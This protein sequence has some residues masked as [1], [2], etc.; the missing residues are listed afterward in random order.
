MIKTVISAE[1][2]SA[3][4]KKNIVVK[5]VCFEVKQGEILTLIGPNGAG[6]STVLK[7][8]MGHL[9]KLGGRVVISGTN[10][11]NISPAELSRRLSVLLTERIRPEL[12]TCRQVAETGRYPYTG[13]F[14]LLSDEDKKAVE[15]AVKAVEMG[16]FADADFNSV[17]D[18]Q[19]QRAMLARAIC[20]EPEILILD[21]PTSYLDIRHKIVFVEILRQLISERNIGVILSMHELELAKKISDKVLCIKDGQVILA[22]SPGE[23]FT[24]ENI[25]KIYGIP[26]ELYKKY[27]G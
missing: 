17:S 4:H 23:I 5:G 25:C 10:S 13:R 6:K 24:E 22:G 7:T 3:G 11:E 20:Q 27:F 8:L 19:R 21:E 26:P 1:G 18:G 12:M 2:L 9:E 15:S 16:N 14:G